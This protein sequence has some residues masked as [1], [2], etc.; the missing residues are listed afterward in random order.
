MTETDMRVSD[1]F[2]ENPTR[3]FTPCAFYNAFL[4]LFSVFVHDS[5]NKPFSLVPNETD[6]LLSTEPESRDSFVGFQLW[7]DVPFVVR[8]MW[9]QTYCN[10]SK[11]DIFRTPDCLML[12]AAIKKHN[13]EK[14][15]LKARYIVHCLLNQCPD[16]E[17]TWGE[18]KPDI[19]HA[20]ETHDLRVHVPL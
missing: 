4:G 6:I 7:C 1:F 10:V 15:K 11:E 3:S 13:D 2:Q 16:I 17:T 20:I 9:K 19:V 18:W 8:G 12:H 14:S 5:A